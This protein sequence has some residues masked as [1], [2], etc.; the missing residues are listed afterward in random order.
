MQTTPQ[1]V[2]LVKRGSPAGLYG[3]RKGR[4]LNRHAKMPLRARQSLSQGL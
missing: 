3:R 2:K 4:W 1:P